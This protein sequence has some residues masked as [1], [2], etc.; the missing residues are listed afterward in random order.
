[1]GDIPRT[2]LS[3]IRELAE[4]DRWNSPS[5]QWNAFL[6]EREEQVFLV[7]TLLIGALVGMVVVAFILLTERF[8]ARLYPAG[9]AAWQRLF[10]PVAGSA[11]MGYL[12]YRFFPE[13]RGS[14]VPQTKAARYARGGRISL[15]TVFGKFFCTSATLASRHPS[16]CGFLLALESILIT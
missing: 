16:G 5:Q 14:G 9:G 4:K 7:L 1:V 8:G 15:G 6:R 3:E 2:E 12:L 11:V 13:A 10:V